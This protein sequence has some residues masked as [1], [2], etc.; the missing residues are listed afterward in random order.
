[1][2]I[3]MVMGLGA[4]LTACSGY[5][6]DVVTVPPKNNPLPEPT[7]QDTTK[8]DTTKW[9]TVIGNDLI[10]NPNNMMATAYLKFVKNGIKDSIWTESWLL[11]IKAKDMTVYRDS[12]Q[13]TIK[14]GKNPDAQRYTDPEF[15]DKYGNLQTRHHYTQDFAFNNF[16]HSISGAW[17]TA[18]V[19][20]KGKPEYFWPYDGLYFE[21]N[22]L[23]GVGD[24]IHIV[25]NDSIFAV[26]NLDAEY[27][28]TLRVDKQNYSRY[29]YYIK[30]NIK[31]ISFVG[32]VEKEE[33]IP[34]AEHYVANLK[35]HVASGNRFYKKISENTKSGDVGY[36]EDGFL[37]SSDTHYILLIVHYTVDAKDGKSDERLAGKEI[38][39]VPKSEMITPA[40]G[41]EFNAVMYDWQRKR[42]IPCCLS[43]DHNFSYGSQ[44]ADGSPVSYQPDTK[45]SVMDGV[46]NFAKDKDASP[47]P[48]LETSCAEAQYNGKNYYTITLKSSVHTNVTTVA[49]SSL[50]K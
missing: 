12:Y 47:S 15:K 23:E 7:P 6:N 16:T 33:E 1:M 28:A 21:L 11:D 24:T 42:Y 45:G 32:M 34:S 44:Y 31:V 50:K 35:G 22:K 18:Y 43:K 29:V 41:R 5:E 14:S 20:V 46:K 37:M 10:V 48:W 8:V 3:V 36:W 49:D 19:L 17:N 25:R 40:K 39:F 26:E 2:A 4:S 9:D 38:I 13:P 27:K 30:A